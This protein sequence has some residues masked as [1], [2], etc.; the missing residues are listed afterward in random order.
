[1]NVNGIEIDVDKLTD[2]IFYGT[3]IESSGA[4]SK[5]DARTAARMMLQAPAMFDALK[6]IADGQIQGSETEDTATMRDVARCATAPCHFVD[7]TV[8]TCGIANTDPMN[9]TDA[10][11]EAWANCLPTTKRADYHKQRRENHKKGKQL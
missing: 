4:C 8:P 7:F 6:R 9:M 10:N 11:F 2:A 1:M 5:S 3:S